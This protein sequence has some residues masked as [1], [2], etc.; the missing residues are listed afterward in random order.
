MHAGLAAGAALAAVPVILH[1][2]MRQTPKHVIFPALRLIRE[3][4][5]RSKK[6][7]KVKNWLLLAAR[8]LLLALMALA[9][10]RPTLNSETS[11]GDQEVPTALAF[12]FDTS[13][14]MQYTERGNNRLAEAKL[15]ANE[16]LKK[17]TEDSEVFVLDSADP[18]KP[19]AISPAA[20]RKRIDAL[21][22]KAANRPLNGAVVQASKAVAASNL[23]RREVYVLTD[24][25][26]S[27]WE[28]GSSGRSRTWRPSARRRRSSRPT[29]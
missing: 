3:R 15:R 6:Q 16:I 8:M 2:F 17:T 13:M 22:L 4:H 26:S 29:S 23:G 10:A 11:L 18:S 19:F 5:K 25:A 21:E 1:L 24:L 14:S 20:A 28:L 27:A 9:L 7:L 12:V